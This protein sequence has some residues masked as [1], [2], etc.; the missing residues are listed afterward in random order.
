MFSMLIPTV[1]Q[2][3]KSVNRAPLFDEV[4]AYIQYKCLNSPLPISLPSL[5]RPLPFSSQ[6]KLDW[7]SQL[8]KAK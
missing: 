4:K 8:T 1:K 7:N 3:L 6:I 5:S 2:V